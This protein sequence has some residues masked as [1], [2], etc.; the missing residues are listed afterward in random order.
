MFPFSCS[1]FG[2]TVLI[3]VFCWNEL[4]IKKKKKRFWFLYLIRLLNKWAECR[5]SNK[6]CKSKMFFSV[7]TPASCFQVSECSMLMRVFVYVVWCHCAC[8]QIPAGKVSFLLSCVCMC[9]L[10]SKRG[11][12]GKKCDALPENTFFYFLSNCQQ[13]ISPSSFDTS[14]FLSLS[15]TVS[16]IVWTYAH[17]EVWNTPTCSP[18]IMYHLSHTDTLPKTLS[19]LL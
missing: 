4:K 10:K 6:L 14:I 17:I 2:P 12:L 9:G 5:E 13:I 3:F 1:C 8:L 16:L 19:R 15:Q 7:R 11:S 18:L